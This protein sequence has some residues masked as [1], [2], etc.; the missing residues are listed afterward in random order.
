[1][2][3]RLQHRCREE[4]GSTGLCQA[5]PSDDEEFSSCSRSIE[6]STSASPTQSWGS[7][8]QGGV[9]EEAW[10]LPASAE[11]SALCRGLDASITAYSE[12]KNECQGTLLSEI[13][14]SMD[15]AFRFGSIGASVTAALDRVNVDEFRFNLRTEFGGLGGKYEQNFGALGCGST[16]E[17]RQRNLL[18]D[19][20]AEETAAQEPWQRLQE[21]LSALDR[22]VS[23]MGEA[24]PRAWAQQEESAVHRMEDKRLEEQ[25]ASLDFGNLFQR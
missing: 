1:M 14:C 16:A 10:A 18:A 15:S 13:D 21:S 4:V 22:D 5:S 17:L 2:S 23:A 12:C 9:D 8:S 19:R 20:S 11:L 7:S 25:L 24:P 3:L 6:G